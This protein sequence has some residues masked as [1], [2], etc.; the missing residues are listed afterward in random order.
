MWALYLA[1][2]LPVFVGGILFLFKKEIIWWEWL[3]GSCTAFIVAGIVHV[4]AF[5]NQ[6]SDFEILS[7]QIVNCRKFSAWQE[8]YLEAVYRTETYSTGSGKNRTTHTRR[9]FS[10]WR[11]CTVWHNEK[12]VAYSNIG[13]SF[14]INKDKYS[15][16]RQEW[17]NEKSVA[18]DRTTMKHGSRQIGGDPL[19]YIITCPQAVVE[20]IHVKQSVV[21][22]LK[23]AKSVFNFVQVSDEIK[24]KLFEYPDSNTAF[25]SSRVLGAAKSKISTKQWDIL[26]AKLGPSK[27]VN[28]IIIGFNSADQMLAEYQRSHWIGGKKNDLVLTYGDGWSKVFGWSDSDILKKELETL[29]LNN[30]I[31][32][33]ILPKIEN[34]VI[35][36]YEKTNWRKF[37]HLTIEPSGLAW[38]WFWIVTV[39]TQV[40]LWIFFHKNEINKGLYPSFNNNFLK[41]NLDKLR[42]RRRVA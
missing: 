17:K 30:I 7:G 28:L 35:N 18:G 36:G 8:F 14:T 41:K 6:T 40:G 1:C 15:N 20:P 26:N 23:S 9:V 42:I 29:L 38:I 3:A 10:H 34:A 27:K 4:A 37:D 16:W 2:L 12:F 5:K 22:R 21:N 24:K 11:P 32:E 31:D 33:S 25:I 13:H 19:D 39:I